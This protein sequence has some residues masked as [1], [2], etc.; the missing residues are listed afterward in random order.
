MS[1]TKFE[2]SLLEEKFSGNQ[3]NDAIKRVENHEPI[4]YV[5]GEWYFR[6]EVYE[7]SSD[8]LIPRQETELVVGEVIDIL[9]R[10]GFFADLCTGSGCIA[11]S[12]LC[13]RSDC[14]AEAYDISRRAVDIALRNAKRNGVSDRVEFRVT[15]V[16]DDCLNYK[17][18]DII[19]SNP[20]YIASSVIPTLSEEVRQEPFIALDG[21]E[22]GLD[23]YRYFDRHYRKNVK[24]GGYLIFEIGFDQQKALEEMGYTVKKDYSGNPRIAVK[25]I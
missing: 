7:V 3:L 22:D 6:N 2:L 21:G 24:K 18:F 12:A 15:D 23:F 13:A 5:L 11:I 17:K 19:V 9:P 14:T 20:P 16:L 4:Q 25:Q 10:N 8:C 1:L